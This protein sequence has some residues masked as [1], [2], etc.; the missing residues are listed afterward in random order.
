MLSVLNEYIIIQYR[1]VDY[2]YLYIVCICVV[3]I[4]LCLTMTPWTAAHQAPLSMEFSRQEYSSG[5]PFPSPQ[6]HPK[7]GI[8][9]RSPALQADFSPSEPPGKLM[10]V[11]QACIYI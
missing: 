8:E 10:F 1:F 2:I 3:V 6:D 7:P 11:C 9:P 4:Q 5:L